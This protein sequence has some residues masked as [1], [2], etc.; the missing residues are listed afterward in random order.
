MRDEKIGNRRYFLSLRK[1]KISN[2]VSANFKSITK[3]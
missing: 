1:K 2:F 3:T